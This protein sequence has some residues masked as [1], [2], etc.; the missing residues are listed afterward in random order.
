MT[1]LLVIIII[2][3]MGISALL[4]ATETA[5]TASSPGK[6][7]KLK[8]EGN[9]RATLVLEVLKKKEK[10]IGT[11][12]IG[13]SLINTVCTTIATS[14]F[15]SLLGH[16][17]TIVASAVMAFI[18]IVFGEVVPKAIAVAK[19][20]Q[21]ALFMAPTIIV[22]LKILKPINAALDYI[23]K[24]FCFI[25]RINL[26]SQISGTE[27]V[28]GVI[29]HYHQEG[30]VYKSDRNMLG[31]ILDIR[32]MVVSEIMTHRSNIIAINIDLPNEVI[33]KNALAL[34]SNTRVPLWQD[35][36][37]NIIGILHLKDLLRALYDNNNDAKKINIKELVTPPWFIPENA[38]VVHQLHAFRERNNHFACV[39][40]E[41]GDLQGIITLEDILE[42]IVGPITDEHDRHN[43][44]IIKQSDSEFIINGTTTI[45]DINRELDWNLPDNNA[46]TIAGLIIHKIARIPSQGEVI[47]IFNLTI[48]INRKIANKI[49]S[50]KITVLPVTEGIINGE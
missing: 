21:L 28:R 39:V 7:Q 2:I 22:F 23:I 46:N 20:E 19:A 34:S 29:E 32:N 9:K 25:F 3:M 5:I 17:G 31:G 13:N 33:V 8:I 43:N 48:V 6:I 44:E 4:A 38:L 50:V 35:N 14:L 30:N 36:R 11:L 49:E 41:Y 45:R 18:I 15:I 27:E 16:S 37:D 24:I 12:L 1:T 42:E 26:K 47:E 40:D 10:V